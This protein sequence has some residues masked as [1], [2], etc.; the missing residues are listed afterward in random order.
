MEK[1]VRAWIWRAFSYKRQYWLVVLLLSFLFA[2][3]NVIQAQLFAMIV[4]Y[5]SAAGENANVI[6]ELG[7]MV[8]W[9][10]LVV[11]LANL[12]NIGIAYYRQK[13]IE[14]LT[15]R[16]KEKLLRAINRAPLDQVEAWHTGEMMTRFTQDVD[17]AVATV[18]KSAI[19]F[20]MGA[21][22]FVT[23]LIYT[24]FLSWELTV[25]I[26]MIMPFSY[27]VN[28][29]F[30]PKIRLISEK[31][32][33]LEAKA[34]SFVQ[35]MLSH[36][37]LTKVFSAYEA[38][39]KT[40][41]SIYSEKMKQAV[42]RATAI[43][44][45]TAG[46][47]YIGHLS[48]IGTL[49]VGSGLV[50]YGKLTTGAMIAYLQII[51]KIVWPFSSMVQI[52]SVFQQQSVSI[53]R[54]L[55]VEEFETEEP[56]ERDR[57]DAPGVE[58]GMYVQNLRFAYAD[59]EP[60]LES[61][62]LSI[63][64]GRICGI[65]GESGAGKSTLVKL[66]TTLYSPKCGEV[67]LVSGGQRYRGLALRERIGYIP[68]ANMIVTGTIRSNLLFGDVQATD[69]ELMQTL[70]AV[71][72]REFVISHKEKLDYPV[73]ENGGNLSGGQAQRI[74]LARALIR[75]SSVLI[76][77]EPTAALDRG[78]EDRLIQLLKQ[79]TKER[80]CIVVSHSA[81]FISHCDEIY[82]IRD[83]SLCRR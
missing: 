17:E 10:L 51:N 41:G 67:A 66:L 64:P 48:F 56:G 11:L 8:L 25:M 4:N 74:A 57:E 68:Q 37:G 16:E 62:N 77:D 31:L 53:Q 81:N 28:R 39:E 12:F 19:D 75:R 29:K 15:L 43:A 33:P 70:E 13:G 2:F 40:F 3:A 22:S 76:L 23:T 50:V 45:L 32:M 82:E 78:S 54:L 49:G 34:R 59:R 55:E 72:L 83:H 38:S 44:G 14:T 30:S 61:A 73:T 35:D 24:F 79:V 6:I 7:S 1:N 52:I 5:P 9:E 36:I 20:L 46:S 18:S 27:L 21:I 47:G 63:R 42:R 69:E 26:F 71:G 80:I 65:V 60:V 58:D